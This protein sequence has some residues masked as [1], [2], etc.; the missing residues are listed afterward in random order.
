MFTI[1]GTT[2]KLTRGDTFSAELALTKNGA[3]YTP[4]NGD[5]ILFAVKTKLNANRTKYMEEQ[6]IICKEIPIDTMILTLSPSD[7]A[8]LPFG[9]YS[10]DI[11]VTL[12]D[13]Q[14]DTV[15]NNA[16]FVIAPEVA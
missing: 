14:V 9:S 2:I 16:A 10:Y 5:S 13:G 6:P 3:V 1:S 7:T 4:V 11:Q 8:D 12:A 15:I